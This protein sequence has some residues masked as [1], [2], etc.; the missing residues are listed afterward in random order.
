MHVFTKTFE[1]SFQQSFVDVIQLV[2]I[3]TKSCVKVNG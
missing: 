3:I 1:I 2:E